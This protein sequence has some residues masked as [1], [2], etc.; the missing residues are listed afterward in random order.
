MDRATW[1]RKWDG[2]GKNE[3]FRCRS[4]SQHGDGRQVMLVRQRL[5]EAGSP[6][7]LHGPGRSRETKE[8]ASFE[9]LL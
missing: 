4:L 7:W 6:A 3:A 9:A 1:W 2:D 5:S 8:E